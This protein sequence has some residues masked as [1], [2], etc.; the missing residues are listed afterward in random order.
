MEAAA[1][2]TAGNNI[3]QTKVI[4]SLLQSNFENCTNPTFHAFILVNGAATLKISP[5]VL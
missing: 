5:Y 2:P 4:K 1:I 3:I